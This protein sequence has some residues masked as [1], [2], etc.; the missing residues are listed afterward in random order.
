MIE[1]FSS[2]III[3]LVLVTGFITREFSIESWFDIIYDTK[4]YLKLTTI[5]NN[6]NNNTNESKSEIIIIYFKK[7]IIIFCVET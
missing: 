3:L 2:K 4:I 5:M 1:K 7:K 6:N